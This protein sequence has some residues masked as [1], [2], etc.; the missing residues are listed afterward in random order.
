[1]PCKEYCVFGKDAELRYTDKDPG[2]PCPKHIIINKRVITEQ[3][4]VDINKQ[5][6]LEKRPQFWRKIINEI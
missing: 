4:L 3:Q 2:S 5:Y 1:L 6:E